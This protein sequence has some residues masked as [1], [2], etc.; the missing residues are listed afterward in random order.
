MRRSRR[1]GS[2]RR[3]RT[4]AST[5]ARSRASAPNG[6][7]TPVLPSTGGSDDVAVEV[8]V[9]APAKVAA[10]EALKLKGPSDLHL[11]P[12]RDG[13]QRLHRV[14]LPQRQLRAGRER[15]ASG[16]AQPTAP[17]DLPDLSY[18]PQS[19]ERL[20]FTIAGGY[21][22][23]PCSNGKD[24]Y[25]VTRVPAQFKWVGCDYDKNPAEPAMVERALKLYAE[26]EAVTQALGEVTASSAKTCGADAPLVT[27]DVTTHASVERFVD[28]FDSDCPW[29][30]HAGRTFVSGLGALGSVLFH[31]AKP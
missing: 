24:R 3:R 29:D 31:F 20:E 14:H 1:P 28:D 17:R 6:L 11:R 5:T 23:A 16:G 18:L 25:E 13:H 8:S 30:A 9:D 12:Q 7:P 15:S 4:P 10:G 27:L 22:P 26:V 19:Y 2:T 21:G